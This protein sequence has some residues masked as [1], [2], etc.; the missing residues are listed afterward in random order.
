MIEVPSR[1]RLLAMRAEAAFL[2]IDTVRR[3]QSRDW[4]GRFAGGGGDRGDSGNSDGASSGSEQARGERH[5]VGAYKALASDAPAGWVNMA[6]LRE[7]LPDSMSREAQD[8]VI[9]QMSREGK[10]HLAPQDYQGRLTERDRAAAV[11][12]GGRPNHLIMVVVQ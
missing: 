12:V 3:E 11:M 1:A 7:K 6:D 8:K 5:I 9:K 4:H 2:G 10:A